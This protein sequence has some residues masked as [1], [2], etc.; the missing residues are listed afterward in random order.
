MGIMALC[1]LLLCWAGSAAQPRG[2]AA[3]AP[4]RAL[5]DVVNDAITALK[6]GDSEL[7]ARLLDSV[8]KKA[9]FLSVRPPLELVLAVGDFHFAQGTAAEQDAALELYNL[10]F[11][12]EETHGK[13][14]IMSRRA[15][16][17]ARQG[18]YEQARSELTAMRRLGNQRRLLLL[19]DLGDADLQLWQ[20][21]A[22]AARDKLI[23]LADADDAVVTPMAIFSLG[24]AYIQLKDGDQAVACFRKLWSRYGDSANV[25]SAVFLVG[26]VYMDR[27][28]F[29]E[30]RKLYEACSVVGAAVQTRVRPGDELVLKVSDPDYYA[31]TRS[32][33]LTVTLSVP[34][35]DHETVRL[36]K[37]RVSDQLYVGRIKT[38]LAQATPEDGILQVAGGDVIQLGYAGQN[39]PQKIEVVDDGQIEIDSAPLAVPP[40]RGTP[41]AKAAPRV[42]AG[43]RPAAAPLPRS[44]QGG[45]TLNPGSP[46]YVQVVDAKFDKAAA[47]GTM[48][49][50]VVSSAAGQVV[51]TVKATLT[52]TSPRSGV[53]AGIV[54]TRA[55]GPSA[56]ASSEADGE[57][58]AW[59]AIDVDRDTPAPLPSTEAANG[60]TT[61]SATAPA[62]SQANSKAT[63][64]RGKPGEKSYWLEIDLKQ[65]S[66][67]GKLVWGPG[68]SK[69]AQIRRPKQMRIILRSDSGER[70]IPVTVAAAQPIGNVID[71]G[72]AFAGVVRIEFDAWEG[73]A[74][75]IGQIIISD[76]SGRQLV[77]SGID[78]ADP[79]L[80]AVLQ[81]DVGQQVYARY[82]DEKN[83]NPGHPV[84]RESRRMGSSYHD[85]FMSLAKV[86]AGELDGEDRARNMVPAW[87][88]DMETP[89]HIVLMDA[90]LDVTPFRDKAHIEVFTQAGSR[91]PLELLET[92]PTT[93][94]FSA[95][96]PVAGNDG[97]AGNP[98]LLY[99]RPGDMLGAAYLD[100]R[101][102]HPGYRTFRY[103]AFLEN[104]PA[105]GEF[106]S[107]WIV[108]E[109]WPFTSRGNEDDE[110]APQP[111]SLEQRSPG[112]GQVQVI[113]KDAYALCDATRAASAK[114]TALLSG[115]ANDL[116]LEPSGPGMASRT[117]ALVL[118]E[119]G[120][121]APAPKR[122]SAS[123][124]FNVAGDDILRFSY[125][126]EHP[127]AVDLQW[128][129]VQCEAKPAGAGK[130]APAA[131]AE[132]A[133]IIRLR[134]PESRVTASQK[135]AVEE[136]RSDLNL[137]LWAY[138]SERDLFQKRRAQLAAR[139]KTA[140]A[141]LAPVAGRPAVP[142][143]PATSPS[144]D[145]AIGVSLALLD[146]QLAMVNSRIDRLK[147]LGA[148]PTPP[149]PA[150]AAIA[151]PPREAALDAPITAGKPFMVSVEDSD[152]K[153]DTLTVRLRGLG[154]HRIQV[155][156]VQAR[157]QDD[158][159]YRAEV[160]T[161]LGDT[162]AADLSVFN[163]IPETS[164]AVDYQVPGRKEPAAAERFMYVSLASDARVTVQNANYTEEVERIQLGA[165]VYV[166]VI[167]Y[168][169]DRSAVLDQVAVVARS[170]VES[171]IVIC[172]ETEPHSGVFRG[173]F[174]TDFGKVPAAE[175][176]VLHAD[177]SS[178]IE[179]VYQDYLRQTPSSPLEKVVKLDVAG[180]TDGIVEAF[181]RQFRDD[182]Q[183]MR[184]WYTTG[185]SAYQIGRQLYMSGS[186]DRA[187]QYLAEASD[188]FNQ[189]VTSFPQD[190][191]AASANYYLGNILA[192]RSDYREAL[193]RYQEIISRWPK[194][195]FVPRARFKI[196][197]CFEAL[198]Q[199]DQA[200]DAYVLLTY[201]H[202]DDSHVPLAMV[203][204]M[205]HFARDEQ[206]L[207]ATAIAQKF[208][209]RF[210]QNPQA[211]DV[212][213]KAGQWLTVAE[214]REEAVAWYVQAEK[215]FAGNDKDMPALLYWHAATL[216]DEKVHARGDKAEKVKELLNRVIYDYPR[217]DYANLAKNAIDQVLK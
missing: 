152:C 47:L 96:L 27:G 162:V 123:T 34:S 36:E 197:Q 192:L 151:A 85:G 99:L 1:A 44:R 130:P 70:T 208:V 24:R 64:W 40:P 184:L 210:P 142:V 110:P 103:A 69:N 138:I 134:N 13:A 203:R 111:Q 169:Q 59:F 122:A 50:E 179:V 89:P 51:N 23:P 143:A 185:Q 198:G 80:A 212:A 33:H 102:N 167:D 28:D 84:M 186:L 181:S 95:A 182:R 150:K 128:R 73:D 146:N 87:R 136:L 71:L 209:D 8:R 141:S 170:K 90:D 81:F 159:T 6:A 153:A 72:G 207:D 119:S 18:H 86:V 30:A 77:P 163:V 58:A 79:A 41:P 202:P 38:A 16:L 171:I 66:E 172:T 61:A 216:L 114:V 37:T 67:L 125:N 45:S 124:E 164:I 65:P 26:Q 193:L 82:L 156:N 161:H 105:T 11:D 35:G 211:G 213:V 121:A 29:M 97:A 31:R 3:K 12:T 104:R 190:Q 4:E 60:A 160:Q 113:L 191:L 139:I 14:L 49:V 131:G 93:G 15:E 148:V 98:K 176:Q 135:E 48:V 157:R 155:M 2:E 7:A 100:E 194:S 175:G 178:P 107:P 55:V 116:A 56:S 108:A 188:Y 91:M 145:E 217:S 22:E 204:M 199:F 21:Q 215:V 68:T 187:E 101:N 39:A 43:Q 19:A 189:L 200:A 94:V 88:I 195:E 206:W 158:G 127:A 112:H 62:S 129:Q 118:G 9:E 165:E 196:G 133:P 173:H 120:N 154:D 168:D 75:A 140:G 137:R 53:L 25:K 32:E 115:A 147:A 183:E 117:V 54:P 5:K 42:K 177:Y 106:V 74:P 52:E 205:N 46:L 180:G 166:Q 20:G 149:Q 76:A 17:F 201:H 144:A 132:V 78:P 126:D 109:A 10:L 174:A 57:H 63:Y 214:H 92:G 83:I